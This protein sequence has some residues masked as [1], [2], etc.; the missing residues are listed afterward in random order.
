MFYKVSNYLLS[1]IAACAADSKRGRS[2]FENV[3]LRIAC[4]FTTNYINI[5]AVSVSDNSFKAYRITY[6]KTVKSFL[7]DKHLYMFAYAHSN[8]AIGCLNTTRNTR[9]SKICK[10]ASAKFYFCNLSCSATFRT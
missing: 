8:V 7:S 3:R 10:K 4:G 5:N 9:V 2:V 1:L 6:S